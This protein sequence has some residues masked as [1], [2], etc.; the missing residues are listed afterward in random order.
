MALYQRVTAGGI[1][2]TTDNHIINSSLSNDFVLYTTQPYQSVIFGCSNTA[3]MHLKIDSNGYIGINKTNPLYH[4]HVNGST[5][6]ASNLIT[7]GNITTNSNILVMNTS[8]LSN[9]VDIYGVL[10]SHHNVNCASNLSVSNKTSLSNIVDIF[11][12]LNMHSNICLSNL[13]GSSYISSLGSNIGI[14]TSSPSY[15]LHVNGV[16]FT[17][18]YI[19]SLSDIRYKS[20]IMPLQNSLS[21]IM[22]INGY[23]YN[24]LDDDKQNKDI[25]IGF[26]AQEILTIVPEV[27]SY[28]DVNDV[29]SVKYGNVV[30]ILV[31]AIKEMKSTFETK[32]DIMTKEL[33]GIKL[34]LVSSLRKDH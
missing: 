28:D 15:S 8:I 14:G 32:I 25:H 18:G 26:I 20:N 5:Y 27:V 31:E 21:N 9:T 17:E 19:S 10:N 33:D 1:L 34:L 30:P 29:Y 7:N 22:Q 23:N 16:V 24:R 12:Q 3:K 13:S 11:S 6:M 2:A 4:L